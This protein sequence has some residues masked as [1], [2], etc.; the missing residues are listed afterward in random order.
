[1]NAL[2][3]PKPRFD[4]LRLP[5]IGR[6][7]TMRYGRLLLQLPFLAIALLLIY[8]GFTGETIAS[9]NLATVTVWVHYR[10]FLVV[11]L[12]LVGN[13]FCMGCPFTLP[14]TLAK[15]LSGRGGRFPRILRNKWLAIANL[16]A[17]F[18]AYEWL[19]LWASPA[20]TA[21]VIVA[22]FVASFVLE[23]WFSESAFCKYVCPLGAFNFAYSTLAPTQIQ[24]RNPSVCAECVGKE[25][26]NGSYS[27]SVVALDAI[28][29]RTGETVTHSPQGTLGCGTLLFVPQLKSNADCTLCLD[30]V[31][32][33]P[34]DNVALVVRRHGQE[35][36]REEA[37][38]KRYDAAFVYIVLAF[39]GVVNAFGM[40]PPVYD[41]MQS[42]AEALQLARWGLGQQAIDAVVLLI[43]F[44]GGGLFLPLLWSWLSAWLALRLTGARL[45]LREVLTTLSVAFVP[46]G[47]G[48]WVAHY[49]YHF[50]TAFLT[51]VPIFHNFLIQHG[52]TAFGTSPQW[53]LS[54][55]TE[56]GVIGA[57]QLVALLGGFVWSFALLQRHSIRLF[58][59]QAI[60]AVLPFALMLLCLVLVAVWIFSLPM[61]MRG[62]VYFD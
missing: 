44:I 58:K 30:C 8:D 54:G 55:V 61:E 20:L 42:L 21:W 52:I 32:A 22:Y 40:V 53:E 19:D 60:L 24:A 2:T 1:M 29:V 31:R 23:A 13:L 45:T 62:T 48:I 43:L 12:L 46:L 5:V 49:S 51:I 33:C 47:F 18:F 26:I 14:R 36:E 7:L 4:L 59:R 28:S 10:G 16:F 15:R 34:H 25:C 3:T 38:P 6:L 50:L 17:L 56:L 41:L 11:A 57:V 37:L 27:P 9:Q 39:V 35:L